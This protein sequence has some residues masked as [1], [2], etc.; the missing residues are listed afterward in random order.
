MLEPENT[1][2]FVTSAKESFE[3]GDL[4]TKWQILQILSSNLILKDSKLSITAIY[5]IEQTKK[6]V[7]SIKDIHDRLVLLNEGASRTKLGEV[8]GKN[9]LWWR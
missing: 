2:S 6:S 5:P 7:L 4:K 1:L 9:E 8:Y 3:N